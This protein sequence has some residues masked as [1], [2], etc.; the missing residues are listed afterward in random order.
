MK[1]ARAWLFGLGFA[2]LSTLTVACGS[3]A[4]GGS[5]GSGGS[6]PGAGGGG[7]TI[8]CNAGQDL[9]GGQCIDTTSDSDNCGGCGI[10][11]LGGHTC[12][13][14]QCACPAG[15]LE[16]SGSCVAS[17][18]THCGTCSNACTGN[19]VCAGGSCTSMCTG[20]TTPCGTACCGSNQT[21]TN[22]ACVDMGTTGTAGSGGSGTGGSG[23]GGSG[24]G[25]S[26]TGGS[27]TGGS[28]TGTGGRG[29]TTGAGGSGSGGSGTGGTTPAGP[30][31]ITTT[32]SSPWTTGTITTATSGNANVTV[33]DGST[34]QTWEGFGG[35]FNEAG[36]AQITKL[37]AA[38]QTKALKLL[39]DPTDGAHFVMGR[40]PIGASDY[41]LTRYTPDDTANDTS[42]NG[43]NIT[44]D[45][46]YLIP[47][48]KAAQQINGSI[49]FWASPWTTPTWMKT[50]SGSAATTGTSCGNPTNGGMTDSNAFDG[51]CMQAGTNNANLTALANIFVK[52]IKAY[53]DMGIV[54]DTLAPQNE[55]NYSQ[56]YPSTIWDPA[57]Y[58]TFLPMLSSALSSGGLS[59]KIMLGTMSNGDNGATSKD[60]Q[61]VQAV[62]QDA[63]AKTIPKVMGLQWGMLDLYEGKSSGIGPSNFM[64]TGSITSVW[65]TEHKCG[66][67]PW[68]PSGFPAY[69]EPA[70]NNQAYAV[71][72]W[73]YIVD[74]I[75][76]GGV[77]A[78][79]A[80]NMVLDPGGKGN[81]MI[82]Q[83]SQDS[84][85]VVN[86]TSLVQTPAYYVFRHSAQYAQVGA[87]V[88]SGTSDP[89]I[90]FKNPDGSVVATMYN[91]GGANA[92]YIVQ[93]KG[94]KYTFSMPASGWATVVVP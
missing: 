68:N 77:T 51:G 84:L 55:P 90:A 9:C 57:T 30:K 37:S 93:I 52:W 28:S 60:L 3:K 8:S 48:V 10:P 12:Q 75:N 80:W 34:R 46:M 23:T 64:T 62:M 14:R 26:G 47:Y 6:G 11:C 78:Y 91:S 61:V 92:N 82:R 94:T 16:C 88:V 24:T 41:A 2:I 49:R 43:F 72:S 59:T 65:A 70:P 40:I 53:K 7:G 20:G 45:G 29:G 25:G 5:P 58:K 83:W 36:W 71:E 50:R 63:S 81:D 21:C 42:T 69:V 79:N 54:I 33:N 87:K 35:A 86:G 32:S 18:A 13:N 76:K 22:N 44:R 19:Q 67:Y 38:D 31:L 74:A 17:D 56:G 1:T 66:N 89:F 39:F 73:G 27:G 15:L 85:L 4:G